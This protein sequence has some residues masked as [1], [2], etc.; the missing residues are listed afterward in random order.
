MVHGLGALAHVVFQLGLRQLGIRARQQFALDHPRQRWHAQDG[1]REPHAANQGGNVVLVAQVACI[2]VDRRGRV[3]IAQADGAAR[4]RSEEARV[5]RDA[6]PRQGLAA[7]ITHQHWQYVE[8]HVG[9]AAAAGIE[10]AAAFD[11]VGGQQPGPEQRIRKPMPQR[12]QAA[13]VAEH[14]DGLARA[15]VDGDFEVILEML[16][17]IGRIVGDVNAERAE[18]R[19]RPDAG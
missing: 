13:V 16:A 2:E 8:L 19:G 3:R 10:E 12:L 15:A 6:M 9:P 5:D 7:H 17:D 4:A 11:H 1:A 18:V 14:A